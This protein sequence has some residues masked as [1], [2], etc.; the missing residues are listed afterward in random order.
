LSLGKWSHDGGEA[1]VALGG[2]ARRG[3]GSQKGRW[4]PHCFRPKEEEGSSGQ[5]G[6]L[7]R[8]SYEARWAGVVGWWARRLGPA[9]RPKP[10][11]WA[12]RLGW[13]RKEKG[14]PLKIDF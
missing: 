4:R 7:G 14:N 2:G 11:E 3:G 12:G 5:V 6:R 10:K 8:A 9:G 13:K 1:G